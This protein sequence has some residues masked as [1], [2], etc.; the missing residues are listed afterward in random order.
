MMPMAPDELPDAFRDVMGAVTGIRFPRQGDTADLALVDTTRG[1]FA[2]KRARGRPFSAW[3]RREARLLAALTKTPL[4]TPTLYAA[5]DE[6]ER[7]QSWLLMEFLPGDS[8]RRMLAAEPEEHRRRELIYQYGAVL[9]QIHACP[10]PEDLGPGDEG[11]WLERMLAEARY[12]L[13]HFPVDGTQELLVALTAKKPPP[14]TPT[15]IHGDFTLDNVLVLDG[16]ITGVVDWS[17]GGIGDPRYD[18]ALAVRTKHPA[19]DKARDEEVFFQGYGRRMASDRELEY[20][21][22]LYEFF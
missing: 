10:V 19:F 20:F 9:S 2:I 6:P 1:R 5:M 16:R 7:E 17:G 18:V 12:N 22:D 8:L 13:E 15:L 14:I 21:T 3:L 11:P 4:P